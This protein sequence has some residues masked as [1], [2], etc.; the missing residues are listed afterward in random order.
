MDVDYVLDLRDDNRVEGGV[1]PKRELDK[2]DPLYYHPRGRASVDR[3]L[4][5][6]AQDGDEDRVSRQLR[7]LGV[8]V[9]WTDEE[10]Y[11]ALHAAAGNGHTPV[12]TLLMDAGWSVEA[13][14]RSGYT[15]LALA[16]QDGHLETVKCILS[17][18]AQIDAQGHS[19]NT[20]LHEASMCDQSSLLRLLLQCGANQKIRNQEGKIAEE[21]A[22]NDEI[23][24]VF[25]E[26]NE[27]GLK[28]QVEF[29]KQAI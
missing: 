3:K 16:T 23:K 18:G 6:A 5:N 12:V 17:R 29:L 10:H 14:T 27:K 9:D 22:G 20:S 8:E 1:D 15:P 11:T 21:Y 4:W 26:F 24:E 7:N 25:R 2:F 13:R 28:N 19:K